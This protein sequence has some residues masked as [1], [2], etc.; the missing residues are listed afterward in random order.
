MPGPGTTGNGSWDYRILEPGYKYNMTDIAAAIGI[1][2]LARAEEMRQRREDIALE[3]IQRLKDV[4]EVE[5]PPV[6]PDRVHAWHLFPHAVA[7]GVV[8][9]R[10]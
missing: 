1:H 3:Y 4:D 6:D 2:Q 10:S 5:L 7:D 8:E 9:H